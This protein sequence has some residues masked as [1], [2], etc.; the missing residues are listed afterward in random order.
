MEVMSVVQVHFLG[1][2]YSKRWI[3]T[4]ECLI[5]AN[6]VGKV[7]CRCCQMLSQ[8]TLTYKVKLLTVMYLGKK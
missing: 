2:C 4:E 6:E 1:V 5:L 7:K 3:R 8:E